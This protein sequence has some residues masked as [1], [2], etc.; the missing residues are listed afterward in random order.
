M[1]FGKQ[2]DVQ[3]SVLVAQR[4]LPELKRIQDELSVALTKRNEM[5]GREIQDAEV[6]FLKPPADLIVLVNPARSNRDEAD[7]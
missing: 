2:K 7:D 4:I 5:L 3:N 1:I 6:R